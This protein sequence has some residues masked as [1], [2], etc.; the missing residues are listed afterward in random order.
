MDITDSE[1]DSD[2]E[3]VPEAAQPSDAERDH[4]RYV[5]WSQASQERRSRRA[6]AERWSPTRGN[7]EG[8][9]GNGATSQAQQPAPEAV[10]AADALTGAPKPR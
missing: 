5:L 8:R 4:F 6:G 7:G 3:S 1:T 2:T 9:D 10:S